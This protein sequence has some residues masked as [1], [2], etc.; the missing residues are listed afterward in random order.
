MINKKHYSESQRLNKNGA[1]EG[2]AVPVPLVKPE[3][4]QEK[5]TKMVINENRVG[6]QCVF[7]VINYRKYNYET[8]CDK[9]IIVFIV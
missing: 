2:Y 4:L 6:Y 7:C 1:Q 3:P 5:D 8:E 9:G